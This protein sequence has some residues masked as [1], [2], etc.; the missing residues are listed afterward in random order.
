MATILGHAFP[1]SMSSFMGGINHGI[2]APITSALGI[3]QKLMNFTPPIAKNA[4]FYG[5]ASYAGRYV[6]RATSLNLQKNSKIE[7]YQAL[8]A[9][10]VATIAAEI[11][12]RYATAQA[13]SK[14]GTP[15]P[16][17]YVAF[18][19]SCSSLRSV[20]QIKMFSDEVY[21]DAYYEKHPE[22]FKA[23]QQEWRKVA[24]DPNNAPFGATVAH[25]EVGPRF[26]CKLG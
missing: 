24:E 11:L 22:E 9:I 23:K 26:A 20:G 1:L 3:P 18:S 21:Y 15:I 5:V 17:Q 14:G 8:L 10:N 6:V 12:V 16:L 4:A 25:F 2:F 19:A 13:L 7:N